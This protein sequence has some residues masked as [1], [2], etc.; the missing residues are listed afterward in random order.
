MRKDERVEYTSDV[1]EGHA[2]TGG[3]AAAGAVTGGVI[4][5]AAGPVGAV[6]GAIGGA[7]VGAVTEG[8]MHADEDHDT[9][10]T[11]SSR[12]WEDESPHY[13]ERWARQFGS[14]DARYEDHEPYYRYGW[15]MRNNPSYRGRTWTELEPELRTDWEGRYKDTPWDSARESIRTAW[16]RNR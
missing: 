9:V 5:M 12:T 10:D 16:D 14:T 11:I 7:I 1:D 3:A 2:T 6:V 15:E 13:R 4:G 8:I